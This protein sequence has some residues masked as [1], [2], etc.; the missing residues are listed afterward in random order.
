MRGKK[1]KIM[2]DNKFQQTGSLIE[3]I[4]VDCDV[5]GNYL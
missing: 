2:F 3:I 1:I 4:C 5:V